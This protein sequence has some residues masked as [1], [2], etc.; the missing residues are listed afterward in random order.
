MRVVS[1]HVNRNSDIGMKVT[2]CFSFSSN[3]ERE[4]HTTRDEKEALVAKVLLFEAPRLE[5]I[6]LNR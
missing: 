5:G 6:C 1:E 4:K 3:G 2:D